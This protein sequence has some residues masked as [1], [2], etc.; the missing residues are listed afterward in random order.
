M[1]KIDAFLKKAVEM[2]ASD[3]HVSVGSPPVVR[4][5]GQ[6]KK[7]KFA[8]LNAA[9]TKALLYEILSPEQI[10]EFESTMDLDFAY[11][12]PDLAR[13]RGN[14][15]VQRKGIDICFRVIK[16]HLPSFADLGIPEVMKKVSENH[17]GLV[18]ITGGAGSG[19]STTL[20]A[21]VDY[22]NTNRAHHVLTVEE[23]IEYV[24]PVKAGAVNQR[25]IGLHT[26]SYANSLKAALRENPDVVMVGEL[27]DLETIS[28]AIS[29]SETGHLVIGSMNTSSAHKTV[30]KII[31]SYPSNQ[32]NQ[33]RAMLGES[34]K[35]VFTQRLL[36]SADGRRMVLAYELLLGSLQL[37]NLIKDGKTF[38]IPN[39][40]QTGKNRGM[41]LMDDTL[42]DLLRAG[43]ITPEIAIKNAANPKTFAQFAPK[44]AIEPEGA[45]P[46]ATPASASGSPARPPAGAPTSPSKP[47]SPAP[48]VIPGR[49]TKPGVG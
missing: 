32:Q 4:Q 44:A 30:D 36:P 41:R 18:L 38:Q 29:A 22:I 5:F 40:M 21:L 47:A 37:G 20:A 31:D 9:Q 23:P 24:H 16:A 43:K 35:A 14:A 17:Q 7:F 11:S 49:A 42:M 48:G 6:L 33:I 10:R 3:L 26:K 28:L 13:F 19:K 46:S 15:F 8:D 2:A 25:Q 12:I 1:A 45:I 34:L 39:L 27:R